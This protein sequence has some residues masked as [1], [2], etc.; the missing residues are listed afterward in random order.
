MIRDATGNLLDAEVDALV[1]TVNTAGVMG[2]GIALQFRRAYPEMFADYRR[3]AKA[4]Q[5]QLGHMHVWPTGAMTGPRYII[6]FPT[7][8][9]WRAPSRL[10]DVD[11]GLADLVRVVQ[12]LGITSIAVPPLGC[13]NGGLDWSDVA[14]RIRSAFEGIDDV[15]VLVFPPGGTPKASAMPTR[16]ARPRMTVGRAGLVH[17]LHRYEQVALDPSLIE[18]QKL[19]YFMQVAGEPLRL[20]Y[21][22]GRYGPYADNL[23][24]VLVEVEGHYLTGF[25]DGSSPVL[26]AE[27]IRVLPGADA[28]AVE[29]LVGQPDTHGRID[30]VLELTQ[31]FESMYGLELLAS[32]HWVVG[33]EHSNAAA[34]PDAAAG[35]VQQWTP[36]K[37]H[38]FAREHLIAAWDA[39]RDHGWLAT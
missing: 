21:V 24:H 12:R 13:G 37:G 8:A 33:E 10:P 15:D 30:R 3:A 32:M 19:L 26:D 1:N 20:D 7:K 38:L 11:A 2:K 4:G 17:L 16:T 9:H 34:D 6:N 28:R 39:L 5:V 27:P 29:R 23:R 25:G 35:L 36:R 31:G 14:P 18:V 22:K